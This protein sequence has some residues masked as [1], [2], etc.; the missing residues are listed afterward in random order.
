MLES[1]KKNESDTISVYHLTS[2]LLTEKWSE[3]GLKTDGKIL[4][5]TRTV[6]YI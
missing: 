2:L 4:V 3:L 5:P 1:E 6:F